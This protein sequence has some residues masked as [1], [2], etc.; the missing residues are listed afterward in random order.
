MA[1]PVNVPKVLAASSV[2]AIGKAQTLAAAG[3]LTLNGAT[4]VGNAATLDTQRR[5]LIT[6]DGDDSGVTFTLI[7]GNDSGQPINE[8][9]SGVSAAA[10]GSTLDFLTVGTIHTSGSIASH[11]T[12][13]TSGTGST[14]WFLPNYNITPFEAQLNTAISGSVTYTCEYTMD[15]FALPANPTSK[16]TALTLGT[17]SAKTTADVAVL[18]S[19][20]I[21][22][23]TTVTSGTGTVTTKFVQAGITNA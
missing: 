11:V 2:N 14:P 12:I 13:G 22:W 4:V 10:V 3:N 1:R 5:V 7:G 23:R 18:T 8:V 16:P 9:I 20:V 6:S 19:P 15:N 21:G 17:I